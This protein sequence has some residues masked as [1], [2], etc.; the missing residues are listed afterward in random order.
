[1]AD[2]KIS[3]MP[4]ANVPLDGTCLV[5]MTQTG[6]NVQTTLRHMGQFAIDTFSNYGVFQYLGADQTGTANQ[7]KTMV[8]D[9]TD[10][11]K[12]VS[13]VA[14]AKTDL[15][16]AVAGTYSIMICVGV[17]NDSEQLD[18]F[19]LWPEVNNVAPVGSAARATVPTRKSGDNGAAV[20][21]VVYTYELAAASTIRF[22]WF[23]PNGHSSIF[24]DPASV[25]APVHPSI[26]GV[27]L[28]AIQIA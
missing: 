4:S 14:P 1:M 10:Y 15:L 25:V 19:T 9:T 24:T 7:V 17:Q 13:L 11:S 28:S 16:F 22:K 12:N 3:A 2:Q 21:T 20:M 23:S 18:N 8:L 6:I 27:I 26:A 5:P